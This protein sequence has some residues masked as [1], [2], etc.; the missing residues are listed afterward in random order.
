MAYPGTIILLTLEY[1]AA[2]WG[3]D[4]R[5]PTLRTPLISVP[6]QLSIWTFLNTTHKLVN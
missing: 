3:Q 2:I 1:H 4:P 6:A 5:G